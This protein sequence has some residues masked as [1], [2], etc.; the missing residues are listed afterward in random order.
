M[1]CTCSIDLAIADQDLI[2]ST[3]SWEGCR[4]GNYL[5]SISSSMHASVQMAIT[6]YSANVR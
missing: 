6:T 2:L 5:C 4:R 3:I 1:A